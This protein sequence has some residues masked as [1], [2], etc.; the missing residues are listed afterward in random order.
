MS[1]SGA[2][3][4]KKLIRVA[5]RKQNVSG[6]L[7]S[8]QMILTIIKNKFAKLPKK[9]LYFLKKTIRMRL[10]NFI[11][12]MKSII[13]SHSYKRLQARKFHRSFSFRNN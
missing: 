11:S 8:L 4:T 12:S 10:S 13:I 5:M 6:L 2:I 7:K 9:N 1:T 3:E